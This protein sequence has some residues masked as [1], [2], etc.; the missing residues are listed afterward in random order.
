MLI[1]GKQVILRPI[2]S[3]DVQQIAKWDDDPEIVKLVGKKFV[4]AKQSLEWFSAVLRRKTKIALAIADK[5]TDQIIG[6][7]ELDNICWRSGS[8]EMR[9]CIGARDYW[10]KGYG[11]DAISAFLDFVFRTTNLDYVFLRVYKENTRAVR[12]YKK[13]GFI[14][15]GMLRAGKRARDGHQDLL[16]MSVQR[17]ACTDVRA[18][19]D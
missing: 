9:I 15:E 17:P 12:C 11:S 13:C 18:S 16:L 14:V 6:D 3:D 19:S 2:R 4:T 8:G 5:T 10:G 1:E 7:L